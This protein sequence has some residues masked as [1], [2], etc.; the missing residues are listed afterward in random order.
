MYNLHLFLLRYKWYRALMLD[1]QK[2]TTARFVT[3][4][5]SVVFWFLLT[6]SLLKSIVILTFALLNTY[7]SYLCLQM[8]NTERKKDKI[9]KELVY[10][11]V[12]LWTVVS[13]L[14]AMEVLLT[15]A[16]V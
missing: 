12:V 6:E 4:V 15:I 10:I 8:V 9:E 3:L 11:N 14:L 13:C 5:C 16:N 1:S 2:F 7:F